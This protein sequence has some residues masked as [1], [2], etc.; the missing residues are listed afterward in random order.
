MKALKHVVSCCLAVCLL[1]GCLCGC[2]QSA[3]NDA[4]NEA[5]NTDA[6]TP[7]ESVDY[8]SKLK[9]NMNTDTVKQEVT[10]KSFID[11]DTVHF[12]VPSS[13]FSSGVLKA[14]FL[15]VNTPESTGKIEEYG[16]K[17]SNF[18]R[19]KLSAATSIIVESETSHW[20]PDSTG[21]RYLVWVWYRT[22]E[23]EDYRNLNLEILQ[24]GLAIANSTA[25][26]RYGDTC[27]AALNQAK[28]E[29]LNIYSGQS[30]PDFYYGDA[31][32]LTLMELRSNI[33]AYNGMKVAFNG[34]ITMNDSNAVYVEA[35]DAQSDMYCGISVYYGFGLSGEGLEIL[36]VGNEARIVGTVQYYE[37]GG[38]YQISDVSYRAMKPDDPNNLQKISEGNA[39]AYRLTD[40]ETFLNG[41]VTLESGDELVEL[42]YAL[43]ALGS[44]LEMQGLTVTDVYTTDNEDS[45]SNGAM[46][47]TCTVDGMKITVR[48]AVLRDADGT[49]ITA[50]AFM[51]KT[52]DVKGIVDFYNGEYQIK[53]FSADSIVIYE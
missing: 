7:H 10:V 50:D 49:V 11:G 18:T 29:K 19:E 15:A 37:V 47:L 25:S 22:S 39:P 13:V 17:A 35:Y 3:G 6:T 46:T 26:N 5:S 32:E 33:E 45:S 38:T 53:V 9:L 27:M 23:T 40:A 41:T 31:V 8:V 1:M 20:D 43:L 51:G 16:K 34:V 21:D 24:N 4:G 44:S 30:D 28:A 36:K 48:T 14:R 2:N 12:H 42:P 52:I